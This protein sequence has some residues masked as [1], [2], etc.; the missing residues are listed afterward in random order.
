SIGAVFGALINGFLIDKIGRKKILI[1]S[2]LIFISGSIF[3][4]F[5]ASIWQLIFSRMFLG[6]A[7][8]IVSFAGPLY[9][10]EISTKNQRGSVVSMYQIALTFG[11]LFSYLTNYFCANLETTWRAMLFTGAIPAF[12][13]FIGMCFQTDTPRWYVLKNKENKAK[14][15]LQNFGCDTNVEQE[16]TNI[17]NTFLNNEKIKFEKRIIM[18]F[19]IGIGIMFVQIATG[20]NAIIYY[21]PTIL[22][23]VGFSSNQDA[24]FITIFIGLI[25]FLMTFVAFAFVDKLGRKPLMYIGLSG[26]LVS[27]LVLSSVFILDFSFVKYLAVIFSAIYI[28]SFSMSLGPIALLIIS[29]I[30]PLKYRGSAM[31]VAIISNFIFNFLITGLFPIS[32]NKFGGSITFLI[33]A[34]ICFVSILFVYF[35]VPE[36][37]GLTLEEIEGNWKV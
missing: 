28:V 15:V 24:L 11:I 18:P 22:K 5:S 26:M 4:A 8:G 14:K 9:L 23:T 31:S 10:S 32:L 33:F 3:C 12:V 20:I 6:A 37:K 17:K 19:I 27:L 35:V 13:L 7:V 16:I 34:L 30:F 29:E 36:T 25:N 21:A 1:L 2:S